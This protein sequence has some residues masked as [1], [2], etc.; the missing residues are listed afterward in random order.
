M[1]ANNCDA[2]RLTPAGAKMIN[3]TMAKD[4]D[5][6]IKEVEAWLSSKMRRE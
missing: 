5:D 1:E 6:T 3:S 4:V 2:C